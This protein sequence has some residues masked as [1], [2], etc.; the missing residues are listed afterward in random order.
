MQTESESKSAVQ[1]DTVNNETTRVFV[2]GLPPKITS[3]QLAEHFG[4]KYKVTDAHVFADRRIGFVG[5]R[6]AATAKLA[7]Q[8][9][10]RSYIRMSKISADLAKP[11]QLSRDSSGNAIPKSDEKRR[12]AR[13]QLSTKRKRSKEDEGDH[14][15]EAKD[16]ASVQTDTARPQEQ[17]QNEGEDERDP[18][19]EQSKTQDND[20]LRGKTS[21]TLDL[22]DPQ[23]AAIARPRPIVEDDD[24]MQMEEQPEKSVSQDLQTA[25]VSPPIRTAVPNARLFLRNL[26]FDLTEQDLRSKFSE[27]GKVQ[28][29]SRSL[30]VH[31][32][33]SPTP[34]EPPIGTAYAI[35]I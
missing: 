1:L 26:D 32:S 3:T 4:S 16:Q 11:V 28:E 7:V 21:R 14:L 24:E 29:V 31:S 22:E 10:N 35:S 27:F 30:P 9:F 33:P 8:H 2:S 20:W 34:D 15:R 18:E 5:F 6:D 13:P 25:G 19:V 12:G 17:Q 23:E